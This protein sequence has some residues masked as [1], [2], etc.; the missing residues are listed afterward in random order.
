MSAQL[1]LVPSSP[2]SVSSLAKHE[3]LA[4][5]MAQEA[6]QPD[7]AQ[8]VAHANEGKDINEVNSS[9]H[10]AR[11]TSEQNGNAKPDWQLL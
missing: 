5:K 7:R 6:P 10:A 4:I 1:S 8:P 9:E 2:S 11:D 3:E